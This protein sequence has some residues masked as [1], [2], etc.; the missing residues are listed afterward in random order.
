M[1]DT[2]TRPVSITHLV[3]GL[4]FLGAAGLWALGAATGADTPDLALLAPGV[5]VAAG[6]VGL[7]AMVLN[8]RNARVGRG[9]TDT[10]EPAY[11]DTDTAVID[12]EETP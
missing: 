2:R 9:R 3:F 8:A 6:V 7:I 10:F 11:A 12:P 4:I 5:L 1:N